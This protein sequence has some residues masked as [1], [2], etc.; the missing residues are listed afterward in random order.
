MHQNSCMYYKLYIILFNFR[1]LCHTE[2][3]F[4]IKQNPP[5]PQP[6]PTTHCTPIPTK[7]PGP[8]HPLT[9]LCAQ[10]WSLFH[11]QDHLVYQISFDRQKILRSVR[12]THAGSSSYIVLRFC[13]KF[14]PKFGPK[15]SP[16]FSLKFGPKFG[17]KF[18]PRF[19]PR[20]AQTLNGKFHNKISLAISPPPHSKWEISTNQSLV[21]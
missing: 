20:L 10:F 1:Q 19:G 7:S 8:H 5:P 11:E 21:K 14:S 15:F 6:I 12:I 13:L 3:Q 17:L 9:E 2:G 18:S 16:K 4:H